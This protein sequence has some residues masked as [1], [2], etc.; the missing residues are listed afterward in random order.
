LLHDIV[1]WN[2]KVDV[3]MYGAAFSACEEGLQR[4]IA[5]SLLQEMEQGN[6]DTNVITY[7]ATIGACEKAL[8]G[9][10]CRELAA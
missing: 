9:N 6:V 5:V 3:I 4:I 1:Q 2:L 8:A 7:N 10:H